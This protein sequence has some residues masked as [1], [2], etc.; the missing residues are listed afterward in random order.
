M[1][2]LL[3][4]C[5]GYR[6]GPTNDQVAG[7]RA[8]AIVPFLND[9]LEARLTD[10]LTAALRKEFQRDGTFRLAAATE[11]D[12]IVRG[13]VTQYRRRVIS[14]APN[15]L[16]TG[17]DYRLEMSVKINVV[18]RATG[19]VVRDELVMGS[20]IIRVTNDL[21]STERQAMPLLAQDTAR[22]IVSLLAEGTW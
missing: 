6:L 22:R 12:V 20:T 7:A 8:I 18:D 13:T 11:A 17:E 1:A 9:T 14:L 4:G 3:T 2:V 15:D 16:A 5:A 10:P 21:T 19:K